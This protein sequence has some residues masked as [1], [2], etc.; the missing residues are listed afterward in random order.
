MKKNCMW[1]IC[2]GLVL[3]ACRP[4]AQN[5]ASAVPKSTKEEP[6]KEAV[7]HWT[8]KTELFMEYPTLV[9]GLKSRF[10]VHFTSLQTFKAQK[11]GKVEVILKPKDGS[12]EVFTAT[13]PSRP[14][15]F[16]VDVQPKNSGEY[17]MAVALSAADVTD[18]H[19][20]GSVRVYPDAKAA[21]HADE[22]SK[23]ET[24]AFLK[25][26]QWA[27]DF[28]TEVVKDRPAREV[29]RV[30]AEISPRVGGEAEVTAPFSGR[31]VSSTVPP[32]GTTVRKGQVMATIVSPTS[33]PSELPVLE[34]AK[35]EAEVALQ[36]ARKERQRA[37][38]LL[39]A[40]AGPA[41]KVDEARFAEQTAEARVSAGTAR[42]AQYQ[43]S[44]EA[45]GYSATTWPFLLRAPITG[46]I[47][48]THAASGSNVEAGTV[49]F[50]IM[51]ADT[52]YVSAIVPEAELP[53]IAQF[54]EAE[55][56][57]P[58]GQTTRKLNRLVSVG[59]LVDPNTRTF[60]VIYEASNTDR[61]L[62]ISQT[63]FA[64]LLGP[65]GKPQ[66]AVPTSAIVDDGGRPVVFIQHGGE[67][68]IRRP[69]K[70]GQ[71][72]GNYVQ[73]ADGIKPGDRV[74]SRGAYLI[75]LSAMS[76]QIPAHGHVH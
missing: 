40:G 70:L 34:L 1:I 45:S 18:R 61:S 33:S 23:E 57:V 20:L 16:G 21:V 38:R 10:A 53:R 49:L 26:Q 41:R 46:L 74:V 52:V 11:A 69:V 56:E 47:T 76:N 15:I 22:P 12:T 4:G 31:L 58:G 60:R 25:E 59:R 24:V 71:T 36:L 68:F 62:A 67:A 32:I 64:R 8:E 2:A 48:G 54:R 75:R 37:E 66:P 50:R 3:S 44:R 72:E 63:V 55:L 42:L 51:D 27:L 13:A 5:E 6:H 65:T 30:P 28:A 43:A 17:D 9:A 35:T 7:S 73:I 14:G 39:S 19:E 29:M